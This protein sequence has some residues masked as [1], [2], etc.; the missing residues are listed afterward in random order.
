MDTMTLTASPRR[1]PSAVAATR[2]GDVMGDTAR[3]EVRRLPFMVPWVLAAATPAERT[4]IPGSGALAVKLLWYA[5]RR[6]HARLSTRALGP[7]TGGVV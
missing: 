1:L 7:T 2:T 3:A 4:H 5:G 6:R